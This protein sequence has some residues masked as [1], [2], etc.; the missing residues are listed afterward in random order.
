MIKIKDYEDLKKLDS[1]QIYCL[2]RNFDLCIGE[3][4]L[5]YNEDFINKANLL[6]YLLGNGTINTE[7]INHCVS[8][9]LLTKSDLNELF[10][11]LGILYNERLK[12]LAD[13]S[14]NFDT[15]LERLFG[16]YKIYELDF[17]ISKDLLEKIKPEIKILY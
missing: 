8:N 5:D 11:V 4:F 17:E 6:F 13:I 1:C 16:A 3:D 10:D 9:K 2:L 7:M 14:V 12:I 15:L